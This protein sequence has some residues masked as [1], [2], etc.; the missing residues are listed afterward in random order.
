LFVASEVFAGAGISN[1]GRPRLPT[2]LMVSLLYRLYAFNE[3]DED[4]IQR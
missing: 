4:L 3:S 2:R 1:A